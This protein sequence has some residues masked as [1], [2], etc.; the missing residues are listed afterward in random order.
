MIQ[1]NLF[2]RF[3]KK[4]SIQNCF[5]LSSFQTLEVEGQTYPSFSLMKG[6]GFFA[7]FSRFM[8]KFEDLPKIEKLV[9]QCFH[10]YDL[11]DKERIYDH[12]KILCYYRFNELN[13]LAVDII[14]N[15]N[16]FISNLMG[17]K[18][19]PPSPDAVFPHLDLDSY[20]SLQGELEFWWDTYWEPF[21]NSLT[22]ETRN[23]YIE[24][25]NL[26]AGAVSFL[27]HH[28]R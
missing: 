24:R 8:V 12:G 6:K 18:I 9:V 7:Y 10:K 19:E 22:E 5:P 26:S 15:D 23:K 3:K 27:K 4:N 14:T 2:R 1:I 11:Q 17:L 28:Q 13:N 21:W 20:G 25:N 16:G